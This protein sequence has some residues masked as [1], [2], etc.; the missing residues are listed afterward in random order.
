MDK[1]RFVAIQYM[2]PSKAKKV[3]IP[4]RPRHDGW[5]WPP[6]FMCAKHDAAHG[7]LLFS[8]YGSSVVLPVH[9]VH[10]SVTFV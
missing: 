3:L 1:A 5:V 9:G 7:L 2:L 8:R 10:W 4:I 6:S